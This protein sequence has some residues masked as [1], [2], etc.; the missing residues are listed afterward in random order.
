MAAIALAI[1]LSSL[2][3]CLLLVYI[4]IYRPR[5]RRKMLAQR[6]QRRLEKEAEAGA[7]VLDI[8]TEG[9][10]AAER[11][12][13]FRFAGFRFGK[14][15]PGSNYED[16]EISSNRSWDSSKRRT[17]DPH[18][19]WE[20]F[21]VDLPPI[22]YGGSWPHS[23]AHPS[24]LEG[25]VIPLSSRI[26]RSPCSLRGSQ[27]F[28]V[29][30]ESGALLSNDSHGQEGNYNAKTKS[31]H[32]IDSSYGGAVEMF[33][34]P[35]T[36]EAV[37]IPTGSP[38]KDIA[39]DVEDD[40]GKSVPLASGRNSRDSP[41]LDVAAGSPF[42]VD[43]A[44]V[45]VSRR[46]SAK[47]KRMSALSQ[48]ERIQ[49]EQPASKSEPP[50]EQREDPRSSK[51]LSQ[52]KFESDAL[53]VSRFSFL[54]FSSSTPSSSEV[55]KASSRSSKRT[56]VDKSAAT[57]SQIVSVP[58]PE[59][60]S[61]PRSVSFDVPSS[62]SSSSLSQP[63]SSSFPYPTTL[64]VIPPSSQ[65]HLLQVP[66]S[67]N[68]P[69]RTDSRR[70]STGPM[71]PRPLSTTRN[72]PAVTAALFP[73]SGNNSLDSDSV[74]SP[75]GSLPMTVSDIYFRTVDSSSEPASRRTS[76][77]SPLSPH[78]PLPGTVTM[79]GAP[80]PV[81]NPLTLPPKIVQ[82]LLGMNQPSGSLLAGGSSGGGATSGPGYSQSLSH[83]DIHSRPAVP[84]TESSTS[85]V[86]SGSTPST[87]FMQRMLEIGSAVLTPRYGQE[88]MHS[89]QSQN[90]SQGQ[91]QGQNSSG[92]SPDI[93]GPNLSRQR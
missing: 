24:H 73:S 36:S 38:P 18:S 75:T 40:V 56:D 47:T 53:P 14:G 17:R 66:S 7:S 29:R 15:S 87:P 70:L 58:R 35:R 86:A 89:R 81:P 62:A 33:L 42:K 54:D 79:S 39:V 20:S 51:R 76:L 65:Q 27:P 80:T 30:L 23:Y 25:A 45:D 91:G 74:P 60:I 10:D 52:V 90:Q 6:S 64:H 26:S 43:F 82:K 34:S 5:K 9:R 19:Q 22:S 21:T 63:Q 71:G 8:S 49:P 55:S 4:F 16:V 72:T 1:I 46:S 37:F 69:Q 61:N 85:V 11:R 48:T 92:A 59:R 31:I 50:R 68:P 3:I 13:S 32:S 93:L 2:L 28:P 44:G 41:F 77:G 83:D 57:S 12:T 88:R 78:P 84:R 67:S